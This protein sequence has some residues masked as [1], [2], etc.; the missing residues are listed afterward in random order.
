MSPPRGRKPGRSAPRTA[1]APTAKTAAPER[2]NVARPVTLAIDVGGSHLKAALL[3]ATGHLVSDRL[4][5]DTPDPLTPKRLLDALVE[6]AQS[7]D[8]HDRVSVGING[9]VHAGR[10]YAI[11]VT[12]DPDFRGFDLVGRYRRRIRRPVRVLNDAQMHGLGF[13][14][15]RGVEVAITLGTGLGSAVFIDGKLGPHVQFL[16]SAGSEDLKGGDYGDLALE[17]LGRKKWSRRVER[18]I[19]LLRRLTNF[20]HLYVGGGNAG[21]L[22]LDLPG[23]VSRGDNSAALLGAV[24]MWDWNVE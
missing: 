5:V 22:K 23:D 15:G 14:R 4:R 17:A 13:I 16:A 21:K 12:A 3:G 2:R 24:R 18:L 1:T 10:I 7:L 8:A 19:D 6:I 11:P 20:D 9:L